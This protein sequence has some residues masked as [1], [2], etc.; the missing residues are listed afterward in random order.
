[1]WN[2]YVSK[3]LCW[4]TRKRQDKQQLALVLLFCKQFFIRSNFLSWF[5]KGIL[6]VTGVGR[7]VSYWNFWCEVL[8]GV[9]VE[10]WSLPFDQELIMCRIRGRKVHHIQEACWRS[11]QIT[12][13]V[14]WNADQTR[15][16]KQWGHLWVAIGSWCTIW[17]MPNFSKNVVIWILT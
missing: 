5:R 2:G 8:P 9:I 15:I 17:T 7:L 1:M 13:T 12:H 6:C 16:F 4:E 3:C 14:E 11:Q 10:C